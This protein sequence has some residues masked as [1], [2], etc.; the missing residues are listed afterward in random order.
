MNIYP[1]STQIPIKEGKLHVNAYKLVDWK[2][3]REILN[4]CHNTC[5]VYVKHYFLWYY[6][7]P[8]HKT[9]N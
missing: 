9:I 6:L 7:C 8:W 4:N 5:P 1:K 2:F 3:L